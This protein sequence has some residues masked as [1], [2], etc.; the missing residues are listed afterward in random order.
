MTG[1]SQICH[2]VFSGRK[3][4]GNDCDYSF[5]FKAELFFQ[6]SKEYCSDATTHNTPLNI[7]TILTNQNSGTRH[8]MR[9]SGM[10]NHV[11][12]QQ[13]TVLQSTRM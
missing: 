13:R 12:E 2:T 8:T 7:L 5:N 6:L 3:W 9:D 10:L 11:T 4:D 1:F